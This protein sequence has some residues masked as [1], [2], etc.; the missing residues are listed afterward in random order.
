MSKSLPSVYTPKE[1][2]DRMNKE[3]QEKFGDSVHHAFY[4]SMPYD[5]NKDANVQNY[6]RKFKLMEPLTKR[7]FERVGFNPAAR[8]FVPRRGG[9]KSKHMRKK[10]MT[11]K[12]KHR[13]MTKR[14]TKKHRRMTKRHRRK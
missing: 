9:K 14:H 10:S 2:R 1:Y 4:P 13:R 6:E 8:P 11:K 7:R 12:R 5:I 3:V